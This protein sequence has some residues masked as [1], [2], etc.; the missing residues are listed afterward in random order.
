MIWMVH[1]HRIANLSKSYIT[2]DLP[3]QAVKTELTDS[4]ELESRLAKQSLRLIGIAAIC[5][6]IL[7][8]IR[9]AP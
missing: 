8:L 9:L 5:L 3:L 2:H 4:L 6:C 7:A 1:P